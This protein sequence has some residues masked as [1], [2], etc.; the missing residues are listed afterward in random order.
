MHH[1]HSKF[2]FYHEHL[3][4]YTKFTV[5]IGV[6]SALVTSV[7]ASFTQTSPE[8]W[9]FKLWQMFRDI[10]F[11]SLTE[12]SLHQNV[13]VKVNS[14]MTLQFQAKL[15]WIIR[16]VVIIF[17]VCVIQIY[18]CWKCCSFK[19]GSDLKRSYIVN[20]EE[21]IHLQLILVLFSFISAT[22]TL[23]PNKHP[24]TEWEPVL[25]CLSQQ[26]SYWSLD[27]TL[28]SFSLGYKWDSNLINIVVSNLLKKS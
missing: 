5:G 21:Q 18:L 2:I 11:K 27:G 15:I 6:F 7:H 17:Y 14:C 20:L 25:P 4:Y 24:T 3:F 26:R 9:R 13:T 12:R 19:R 22:L 23:W 28:R 10:P 1:T 8:F 16:T